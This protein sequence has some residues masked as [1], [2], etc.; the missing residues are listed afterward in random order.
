[1]FMDNLAFAS[2]QAV[3]EALA[4]KKITSSELVEFYRGRFAQ[5]DKQLLSALEIFDTASILQRSKPGGPLS[6][7]P[8]LMKDNIC[9]QG[10]RLTCGSKI[11]GDY[12]APYDATV[13]EH[14]TSAGALFIGRANLDEFAMG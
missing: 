8:G 14:L 3:S 7:I 13:T 11:L 6:G 10:R 5:Y 9:M 12:R 4:H 1:M 2:I